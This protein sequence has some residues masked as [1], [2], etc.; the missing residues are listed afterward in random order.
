MKV[1][2][3]FSNST[4]RKG[5]AFPDDLRALLQKAAD[6]Q[7]EAMEIYISYARS[8]SYL[9]S[10]ERVKIRDHRNHMNLE[11]YDFVY[12][13]K[14]GSAMQQMQ[15]CAYYLRDRGVPFWDEELLRANSRN[16]LTQMIM[17][18][19]SGLPIAPTLFCRNRA[20]LLRL[21]T[22]RHADLF[23]FPIILKATGGSRGDAN[24]LI[25]NQEM[26]LETVKQ[27]AHRSFMVQAYIPNDGDHRFFV[28]GGVLCGVI[29]RRPAD[30][31][32]LSNTSKGGQAE[33]LELD[34][35]GKEVA[36]QSVQ[37]AQLFGRNVAGVDIMFDKRT[38]Q[39]YFLEVNRAPQIERAS[40]E[41]EKAQ[42][43]VQRIVNASVHHQP[44]GSSLA[45]GE[46]QLIGRYEYVTLKEATGKSERI[47]A[48][49]D[50]GADS[51]SIHAAYVREEG[52]KLHFGIHGH[53]MSADRYVIK[54]VRST[55]GQLD[56]RYYV[57]IP[58][59]IGGKEYILKTTLSDRSA[60]RSGMLIGRRFLREHH[61]MVDVS[62]RFI[63][64]NA[65]RRS[66]KETV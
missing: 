35:F 48:K 5:R 31:G 12:F 56:A 66:R 17:L 41:D 30:G 10:N 21:V 4:V 64:S 18:Q 33:L 60:M 25:E 44:A 6:E 45:A 20:R 55:S 40:F 7:G 58:I 57:T 49:T 13:R 34:T 37:A 8:L 24:Y 29:G 32:H 47:V 22:K 43:V 39:H 52:G 26:L 65:N 50:T 54:R 16:K 53:D 59:Y 1:L 27:E 19:R 14:A 28:A 63:L 15:T 11:D 36:A 42:W 9:I 62:R 2:L 46:K 23:P 3:L 51:S 38:G 61:L